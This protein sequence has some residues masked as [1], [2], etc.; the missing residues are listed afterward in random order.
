MVIREGRQ[1][2][3]QNI[4][5]RAA[6]SF[7]VV[8]LADITTKTH[9]NEAWAAGVQQSTISQ[10]LDIALQSVVRARRRP[11]SVVKSETRAN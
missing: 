8:T 11:I 2:G 4:Q 7:Y 3:G 1:G 10:A 9:M 5:I 6:A